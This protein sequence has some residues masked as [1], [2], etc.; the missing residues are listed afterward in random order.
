MQEVPCIFVYREGG[1]SCLGAAA[2]ARIA[3]CGAD[4]PAKAAVYELVS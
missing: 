1:L 4:H 2:K 3:D